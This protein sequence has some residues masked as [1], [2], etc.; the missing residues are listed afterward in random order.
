MYSTMEQ[1]AIKNSHAQPIFA[2]YAE[3]KNFAW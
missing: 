3:L 2:C 1:I